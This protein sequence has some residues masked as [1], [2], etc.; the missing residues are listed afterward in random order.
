MEAELPPYSAEAP[1]W[2]ALGLLGMEAESSL[3]EVPLDGAL[4]TCGAQEEVQEEGAGL[5]G[6]QV[7]LAPKPFLQ[8]SL[9]QLQAS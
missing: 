5:T 4:E 9:V 6:L 8:C 1:Y 2:A 3:E 7:G